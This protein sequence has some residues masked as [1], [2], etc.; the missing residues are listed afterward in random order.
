[1]SNPRRILLAFAAVLISTTA[2]AAEI[3]PGV[4]YTVYNLPHP[5][6][7]HVVKID[8]SRPEY[9]LKLGFPQKKRNYTARETTSTIANRYD[10]PPSHDVLAAVNGSFFS[11]GIGITGTLINSNGF[12]QLPNS[13]WETYI[14]TDAR[15]S[16]IERNVS[17]SGNKVTFANGA[18]LAIDQVDLARSAVGQQVP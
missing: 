15:T 12:I 18:S 2:W 8:L 14:F 3:A 11:T 17:S 9:K 10:A 7:A 13:S 5:N 6:V 4:E 1:M 16:R